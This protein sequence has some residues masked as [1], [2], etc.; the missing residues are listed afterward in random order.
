MWKATSATSRRARFRYAARA[1]AAT[2]RPAGTPPTTGPA[3]SRSRSCP[4]SYN[5]PQGYLVTAN[6]AV[7]GPQYKHLLTTDWSYG[8]RSQRINDLIA[9]TKGRAHRRR[10]RADPVRQLQRVRPDAGSRAGHDQAR[11]LSKVEKDADGLLRSGTSC[12]ATTRP[13]RPTTTR[14]GATCSCAPSTSWARSTR[15]TAATAGSRWCGACSSQPDTPWWDVKDT[16]EVEKRDDML[17]R[18]MAAAVKELSDLQGET[19]SDWRWGELHTLTPDPRDL[20]QVGHLA[21]RVAFQP[22]RAGDRGRRRRSSTPPDGTRAR[23]TRWTRCH[24]CE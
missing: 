18:A 9:T 21:D 17:A 4:A 16:P 3:T 7:I 15:P 1:T 11:P 14:S 20:R 13:P 8:Y 5:P 6:Q 10:R 22:P 19:A 12:R 2:W 24:A 23:A